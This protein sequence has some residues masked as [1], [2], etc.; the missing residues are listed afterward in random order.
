M[1]REGYGLEISLLGTAVSNAKIMRADE[2][3]VRHLIDKL[4]LWIKNNKATSGTLRQAEEIRFNGALAEY[5]H[6]DTYPQ[7]YAY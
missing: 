7:S 6:P 3:K 5:F 4:D 2:Q 1:G